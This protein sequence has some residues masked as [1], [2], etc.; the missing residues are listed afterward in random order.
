MANQTIP[1]ATASVYF[2][3]GDLKGYRIVK[4]LTADLFH[5]DEG[6]WTLELLTKSGNSMLLAATT[7]NNKVRSF[8]SLDSIVNTLEKI[9]FKVDEMSYQIGKQ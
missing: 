8:K 2:H 6:V 3:N 4:S 7:D 1:V 5:T 9:G